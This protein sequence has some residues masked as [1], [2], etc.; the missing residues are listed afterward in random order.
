MQ[1]KI[2]HYKS[3]LEN[4]NNLLQQQNP[5]NKLIRYKQQQN[6]L[7]NRLNIV[8][9]HKLE[10]L[11]RKYI[12]LVHTLNAVSPLSTLERGYAIVT[13]PKTSEVIRS[14]QQ[15]SIND[16]IKTRLAHGKIISQ[17]KEIQHD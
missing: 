6:Y 10:S 13:N 17:I 1:S 3:Q 4:K 11:Q 5:A 2:R 14:S 8:M 9:Q 15:L 16:I 12:S 7:N